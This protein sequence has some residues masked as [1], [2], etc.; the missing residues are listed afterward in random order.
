MS[1]NYQKITLTANS[2]NKIN[3]RIDKW[4]SVNAVDLSRSRAKQ[5]LEQNCVFK[6]DKII[7]DPA[8]KVANGDVITILMP[9]PENPTPEGEKIALDIVY[10]DN[11][12]IVINKAA[13]MVIH[14]APGNSKG[15]LVNA[16][17]EH[18]QGSLS[19]IGGVKRPGIVHRIDKDTSGLIVVAKND[20]AHNHLSE[21]FAKHNIERAYIAVVWN[22]LNPLSGNITTNIGRH[23]T[24][25]KKMAVLRTGGKTAITNYK[26]LKVIKNFASVVECRLETGRT[27]QIRVHLSYLKCPLIGDQTYGS[28]KKLAAIFKENEFLQNF[29]RQALHAYV[30]GFIH[31]RTNE[32]ICFKSNLPYDMECLIKS[33][34]EC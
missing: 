26:T 7:N 32:K 15:T 5:L 8:L 24:N 10:E 19:G 16:L 30:L 13:D 6:N 27:H 3:E 20:F 1:N 4:I 17:I 23:K 31:P 11:D 22:I 18:C 2:E 34:E 9:P 28:N 14:P 12:L 33:L 25:R 21:Q 29:Q